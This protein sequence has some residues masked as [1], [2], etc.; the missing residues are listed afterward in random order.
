MTID[1]ASVIVRGR[2]GVG[3]AHEYNGY[4]D[5]LRSLADQWGFAVELTNVPRSWVPLL[6]YMG[7]R[8]LGSQAVAAWGDAEAIDWHDAVINAS[9]T[10]R[11]VEVACTLR[12]E[13]THMLYLI[14]TEYPE[15]AQSWVDAQGTHD[16]VVTTNGS[17]YRP[18]V[19]AYR[20][21]LQSYTPNLRRAVLVPCTAV[22][23][24]PAP[25]HQAVL[26]RLPP[27]WDV[28]VVSGVLG[29]VPR[30]LWRVQP[31]Y[32]AGLPF[33]ERVQ[34]TV[35]WY[36]SKHRYERLIVYGDFNSH[37]VKCGLMQVP[38]TRVP[39]THFCFGAYR[40]STYENLLDE[41]YLMQLDAAVAQME[42]L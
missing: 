36:F 6:H 38:E 2:V 15:I 9:D 26:D 40:R 29:I 12:P 27:S 14:D 30:D 5:F 7:M 31:N 28:L 16:F 24:Y 23:P 41:Q 8:V 39:P 3:Y 33:S 1:V 20:K 25:L 10:R 17:F 13:L 4:L 42:D 21:A 19:L 34:D 35:L 22:K 37:A 32:D 11:I 18:E